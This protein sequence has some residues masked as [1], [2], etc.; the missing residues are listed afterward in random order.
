MTKI[1]EFSRPYLQLLSESDVGSDEISLRIVGLFRDLYVNYPDPVL[2]PS[3][4]GEG[5]LAILENR[6]ID[7]LAGEHFVKVDEDSVWLTF[8]GRE[9]VRH[10]CQMAPAYTAF[11]EDAQSAPP[12]HAID[13]VLALLKTHFERGRVSGHR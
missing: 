6:I 4:T 1:E 5:G 12:A 3:E 13:L 7:W 8:S 11:F 9:T 10:T 2:M